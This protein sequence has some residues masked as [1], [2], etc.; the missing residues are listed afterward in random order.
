M[1]EEESLFP[2]DN[3][4]RLV[5]LQIHRRLE[6]RLRG[7][8]LGQESRLG[9]FSYSSAGAAMLLVGHAYGTNDECEEELILEI[10]PR[11]AV[12]RRS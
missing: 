5:V 3:T 12:L 2:I 1:A 6:I 9:N 4:T 10:Y 8:I 7:S 11:R